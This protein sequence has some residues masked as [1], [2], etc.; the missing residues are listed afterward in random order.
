MTTVSTLS[1]KDSCRDVRVT[2]TLTTEEEGSTFVTHW[3]QQLLQP[4]HSPLI[5][6]T[7]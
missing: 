1:Q 4:S 3:K 6:A 5:E 7:E 2:D